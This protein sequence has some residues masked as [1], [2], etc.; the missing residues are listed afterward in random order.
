MQ[1]PQVFLA[2]P[3]LVA[4]RASIAAGFEGVD[5][6]ETIERFTDLPVEVVEGD[7]RNIKV[8]FIEDFFQAE[9][10]AVDWDKGRWLKS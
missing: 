3:L 4:Y 8:T 9:E 7:P 5:T 6:A 1:T 10:W 2:Q